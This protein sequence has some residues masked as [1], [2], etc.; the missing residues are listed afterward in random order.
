MILQHGGPVGLR[1]DH[2]APAKG[3][4]KLTR[5][6][7]VMEGNDKDTRCTASRD[8]LLLRAEWVA[9]LAYAR[10]ATSSASSCSGLQLSTA[11]ASHVLM[12][13]NLLLP[14]SV[15]LLIISRRGSPLQVGWGDKR[16]RP[17]L[18]S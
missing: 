1:F 14:L 18:A 12:A 7:F 2:R 5:L 17:A 6:L 11:G 8:W 10:R 4:Q 15:C 13:I 3:H 16:A 9:Y